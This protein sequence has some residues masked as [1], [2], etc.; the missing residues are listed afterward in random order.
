MT[1]TSVEQLEKLVGQEY[2]VE[3]VRTHYPQ[4]TVDFF[5]SIPQLR[6]AGTSEISSHTPLELAQTHP[7]TNSYMVCYGAPYSSQTKPDLSPHFRTRYILLFSPMS[8]TLSP[9][10]FLPARP[11][12]FCLPH[13]SCRLLPQ[14]YSSHLF[15]LPVPFTSVTG[16]DQDVVDFADRV[17]R[18]NTVKGLPTFD[19]KRVVHAS[20]TIE[21]L[22]PLPL[23]SGPGWKLKKRLTS[24]R[25][26]SSCHPTYSIS[27]HVH[28]P[29][30]YLPQSRASSSRSSSYSWTPTARLMLVS[31]CVHSPPHYV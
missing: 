30:S 14:R 19:P 9:S 28:K 26:N 13:I 24:I 12:V 16:A 3:P 8:S 7:R 18:S 17:G 6:S 5:A 21:V 1:S 27:R 25:E 31:S 20:Q 10:P 15:I 11:F 23:V 22:K 29:N 4:S 2:A